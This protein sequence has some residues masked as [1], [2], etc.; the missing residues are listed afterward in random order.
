MWTTNKIGTDAGF[1]QYREAWRSHD[2]WTTGEL[3]LKKEGDQ[4]WNSGTI[5][6]KP[7]RISVMANSR[8]TST[9]KVTAVHRSH[10]NNA[11]QSTHMSKNKETNSEYVIYGHDGERPN[12]SKQNRHQITHELTE[13]KPQAPHSLR[14][15]TAKTPGIFALCINIHGMM[16][17]RNTY[18]SHTELYPTRTIEGKTQLHKKRTCITRHGEYRMPFRQRRYRWE[19]HIT[20][21]PSWNNDGH[22]QFTNSPHHTQRITLIIK[23]EGWW[24]ERQNNITGE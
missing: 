19:I 2:V 21:R 11:S 4:L 15:L 18:T 23:R 24:D 7:D 9:S 6:R 13:Y 5:L 10:N 14:H 16:R 1:W 3:V 8:Y 22:D 17:Q 20:V 12:V